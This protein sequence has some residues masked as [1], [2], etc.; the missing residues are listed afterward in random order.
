VIPQ[1]TLQLEPLFK[2]S[3]T[4][5]MRPDRGLENRLLGFARAFEFGDI[6]WYPSQRVA[7]F[8]Q[9]RR[10]AMEAEGDGSND[11]VGFQAQEVALVEAVRELGKTLKP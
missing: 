8:K 9:A 10:V 5:V 2:Q 1:V 7:A 4:L 3:V 11:F 6:T